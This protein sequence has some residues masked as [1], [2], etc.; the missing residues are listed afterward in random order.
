MI[1]WLIFCFVDTLDIYLR[2]LLILHTHPT[3]QRFSWNQW[4][5]H[6]FL[7]LTKWG[8]Q[9]NIQESLPSFNRIHFLKMS[10]LRDYCKRN[11]VPKM[12]FHSI[13]TI[14]Y[15]FL[16]SNINH[17]KARFKGDCPRGIH[18]CYLIDQAWWNFTM[19]FFLPIV[20]K[21]EKYQ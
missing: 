3:V 7:C 12:L 16:M 8:N 9:V 14:P 4:L 19:I 6:L 2:L 5:C 11:S 20:N 15:M 18:V 21:L 13:W 10:N 1:L 17:N